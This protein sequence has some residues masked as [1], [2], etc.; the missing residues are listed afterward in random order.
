MCWEDR[1][2]SVVFS[3]FTDLPAARFGALAFVAPLLYRRHTG[4]GMHIDLS[5]YE[6]GLHL[7]FPVLLDYHVNGRIAVRD[8]N[9]HPFAAPPPFTN[10]GAMRLGTPLLFSPRNTGKIMSGHG[11][12]GVVK[13]T[14]NFHSL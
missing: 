1:E 3:G 9:H 6:T 5:K 8:V 4:K 2:S 14:A 11:T 12:P 13:G 7:I 10:V